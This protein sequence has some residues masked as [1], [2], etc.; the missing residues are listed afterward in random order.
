MWLTALV[1][2]IISITLIIYHYTDNIFIV[3]WVFLLYYLFPVKG[4]SDRFRTSRIMDL[5]PEVEVMGPGKHLAC[6]P[7]K[8]C[9]D[10]CNTFNKGQRVVFAM[11]P[12]GVFPVTALAQFVKG[13]KNLQRK[14]IAHSLIFIMPILREI[15][16]A[17]GAVP[18]NRQ[19]MIDVLRDDKQFIICPGAYRELKD[20]YGVYDR[21][22]FI[23]VAIEAGQTILVPMWAADEHLL[24]DV[25]LPFGTYFMDLGFFKFRYPWIIIAL[26]RK[27]LRFWPKDIG[28]PI[29]LY[30]GDP[31][32]I[33][34][35][36][37]NETTTNTIHDV[38][39][40]AID[41]L[42]DQA[43]KDLEKIKKIKK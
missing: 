27:W 14:I 32:D 15:G 9:C 6:E 12:H 28:R 38:F 7:S 43:E 10:E 37:V 22:G 29:R 40:K 17:G 30:I 18:A 35:F 8:K 3:S 39:Y 23:N 25:Y 21:Y 1:I 5:F 34:M 33:D 13:V 4:Q 24:Y 19:D 36:E 31:I 26:G 16:C 20:E 42:K 2:L 11:H 41:E